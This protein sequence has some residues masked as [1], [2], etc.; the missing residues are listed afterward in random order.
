MERKATGTEVL[1]PA[2][3]YSLVHTRVKELVENLVGKKFAI[4]AADDP[5]PA[6]L[7][8]LEVGRIDARVELNAFAR[9][10]TELL[11]VEVETVFAYIND[12]LGRELVRLEEELGDTGTT[13]GNN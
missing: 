7:V 13:P 12:E 3:K 4:R 1:N 9:I 11:G 8:D 10:L 5:R 2:A 6:F